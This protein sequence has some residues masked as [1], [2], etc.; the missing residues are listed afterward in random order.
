MPQKESS[1]SERQSSQH[2][3]EDL[4]Y[5]V[6]KLSQAAFVLAQNAHTGKGEQKERK[7]KAQEMNSFLDELVPLI[8]QAPIEDQAELQQAWTDARLDVGYV[9]S[10]GELSSSTRLHHYIRSKE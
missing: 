1:E 6:R 7:E 5:L 8:Q 10:D 4:A 2:G 3:E 9:L